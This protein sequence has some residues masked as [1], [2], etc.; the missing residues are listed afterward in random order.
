MT[1]PREMRGRGGLFLLILG[2]GAILYA[3]LDPHRHVRLLLP[4][5]LIFLLGAVVILREILPDPEKL[6]AKFRAMNRRRIARLQELLGLRAA[7]ATPEPEEGDR[8]AEPEGPM[9]DGETETALGAFVVS[10]RSP[11]SSWVPW[12]MSLHPDRMELRRQSDER[13][14]ALYRSDLRPFKHFALS[15]IVLRLDRRRLFSLPPDAMRALLGWLGGNGAS[16]IVARLRSGFNL[17]G[18]LFWLGGSLTISAAGGPRLAE[19][20]GAI[21]GGVM[22][23][24]SALLRFRPGMRLLFVDAFFWTALAAHSGIMSL[25]GDLA[26]TLFIFAMAVIFAIQGALSYRR[27]ALAGRLEAERREGSDGV[28]TENRG[29]EEG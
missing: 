16:R 27:A 5:I 26:R 8:P 9:V 24:F 7:S 13:T 17:M 6:R 19:P 21:L 20:V 25:S 3:S 15:S 23:V 14:Y 29:I 12:T 1:A 4:G 28:Q 10:E 22:L 18:G 2:A 11:F